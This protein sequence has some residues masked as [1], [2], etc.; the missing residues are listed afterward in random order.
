M[1]SMVLCDV[2]CFETSAKNGGSWPLSGCTHGLQ[3]TGV[4]RLGTSNYTDHFI[5]FIPN[6][7]FWNHISEALKSLF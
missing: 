7:L 2:V 6:T 3:V 5:K 4:L 1:W